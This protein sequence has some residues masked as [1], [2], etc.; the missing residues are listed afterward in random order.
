LHKLLI[1]LVLFATLAVALQLRAQST[2]PA[3]PSFE[4]SSVKRDT[5]DSNPIRLGGPD[6]SRFTAT[7]VTAKTLIDFA[8]DLHDFNLSG[9]PSWIDSEK[10][11]V[12][13]KVEDLLAEHLRSLPQDQQQ[14]EI[15]RM[16]QSLL[17]DRFKLAIHHETKE[18]PIFALVIAKGGSKLRAVAPSDPQSSAPF[19]DFPK[20]GAPAL[21]PGQLM[22]S[23]FTG[24]NASIAGKS[25]TVPKLAKIL[26]VQ[27]GRHVDDRTGLQGSYDVMLRYTMDASLGG[28]KYVGPEDPS[29]GTSIFTAIQEQLGLKLE[30]AKGPV[31]TIVI[32]HIEEPTPN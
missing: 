22:I 23:V 4:V 11:D 9:G 1:G 21:A 13:G 20:P 19:P 18:L 12:D 29:G 14:G 16:L 26:E 15:R 30:S 3:E 25:V 8:Y 10:F 27:F 2:S 17:A 24:G 28:F 6:V 7:N 32:D 5:S 31:D